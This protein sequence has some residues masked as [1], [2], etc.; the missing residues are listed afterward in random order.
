MQVFF[1]KNRQTRKKINYCF[2]SKCTSEQLIIHL[3]CK[4]NGPE[5]IIRH[6]AIYTSLIDSFAI[7]TSLI[8]LLLKKYNYLKYPLSFF[9][10]IFI[11]LYIPLKLHSPISLYPYNTLPSPFTQQ[12]WNVTLPL[13]TFIMKIKFLKR[14]WNKERNRKIKLILEMFF[15]NIISFERSFHNIIFIFWKVLSR[16][17][18]KHNVFQ[19]KMSLG[20]NED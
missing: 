8:D 6:F 5:F 16:K 10:L 4:P 20:N 7:Y 17:I 15:Q 9:D 13:Q 1:F 19:I 18:E 14:N 12:L 3:E 2:E 11:Y